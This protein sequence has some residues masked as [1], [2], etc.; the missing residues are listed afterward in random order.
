MSCKDLVNL[1]STEKEKD[2]QKPR[3]IETHLFVS[4]VVCMMVLKKLEVAGV[5]VLFYILILVHEGCCIILD[6]G[7]AFVI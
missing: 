5:D 1:R 2:T 3:R 6:G 4:N 7:R